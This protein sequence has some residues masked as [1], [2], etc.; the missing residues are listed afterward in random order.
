MDCTL[1]VPPPLVTKGGMPY[2]ERLKSANPSYSSLPDGAGLAASPDL[3]ARASVDGVNTAAPLS[4]E[5]PG[6]LIRCPHGSAG[7]SQGS[8]SGVTCPAGLLRGRK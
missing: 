8:G 2:A 6:M 7:D 4:P 5:T 3:S 1:V